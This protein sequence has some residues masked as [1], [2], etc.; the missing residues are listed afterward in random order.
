M[1]YSVISWRS[2]EKFEI[3]NK[4][5]TKVHKNAYV[6][7]W[8]LKSDLTLD[9]NGLLLLNGKRVWKKKELTSVVVKVFRKNKSGG[10]KKLRTRAVNSYI[11]LN[12]RDILRITKNNVKYK[13]FTARFTNKALQKLVMAC[14]VSQ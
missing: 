4:L 11:G 6:K 3:P 8:G 12:D 14:E 2:K 13:P 9:N 5:Q 1:T 7:Y 10:N